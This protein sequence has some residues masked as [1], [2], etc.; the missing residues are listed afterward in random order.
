M[1]FFG[2]LIITLIIVLQFNARTGCHQQT[3]LFFW[4]SFHFM[5]QLEFPQKIS[6]FWYFYSR[7]APNLSKAKTRPRISRAISDSSANRRQIG[8][9][10]LHVAKVTRSWSNLHDKSA[11]HLPLLLAAIYQTSPGKDVIF[12]SLKRH[13]KIAPAA[14]ILS[15]LL[16]KKIERMKNVP[17]LIIGWAFVRSLNFFPNHATIKWAHI[18][19]AIII[20]LTIYTLRENNAVLN[21]TSW[22]F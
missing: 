19:S 13:S 4:A 9:N 1:E 12:N 22:N 11:R 21:T 10:F 5:V 16:H 20:R 6:T 8:R 7:L 3:K 14:Q 17:C 18:K 2:W 15:P